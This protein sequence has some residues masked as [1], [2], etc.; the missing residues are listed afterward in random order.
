MEKKLP[1]LHQKRLICCRILNSMK[2]RILFALLFFTLGL[3]CQ[4]VTILKSRL[5]LINS[6][7]FFKV[8]TTGLQNLNLPNFDCYEANDVESD[9]IGDSINDEP[10]WHVQDLNNDGL[11]DL[12]YTGNCNPYPHVAVFFNS[13]KGFKKVYDN[14]GSLLSID[15]TKEEVKFNVLIEACCCVDYSNLVEVRIDKKLNIKE[16]FISYNFDTKIKASIEL[17]TISLSGVL[18]T[19]PIK[20]DKRRKDPC[21]DKVFKGN[22]IMTLKDEEVIVLSQKKNWRQVLVKKDDNNS[23]IGWIKI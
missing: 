20:E 12:V 8:D 7:V 2:E 4:E 9:L 23:I 22:S 13:R 5:D 10:V 15:I 14:P 21:T 17:R 11:M 1:C 3:Y 16:H 18:R 19:T 6:E